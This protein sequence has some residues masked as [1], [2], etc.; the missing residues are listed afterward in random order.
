MKLVVP[1]ED[2]PDSPP[3]LFSFSD[4]NLAIVGNTTAQ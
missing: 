4:K 2:C 1:N 3:T